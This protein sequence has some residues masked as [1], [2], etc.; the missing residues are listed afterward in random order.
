MIAEEEKLVIDRARVSPELCPRQLALR[1][2]DRHGMLF[3]EISPADF[4]FSIDKK[5]RLVLHLMSGRRTSD[6]KRNIITRLVFEG[7]VTV[8]VMT[9][10][11]LM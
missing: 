6:E 8:H 7:Q 1:L 3:L 4:L 2:I 9:R 5:V 11:S 10:L